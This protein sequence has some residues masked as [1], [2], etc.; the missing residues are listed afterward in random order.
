MIA[1]EV[2]LRR[3][4]M[5]WAGGQAWLGR[6]LGLTGPC[7]AP[8]RVPGWRSGRAFERDFGYDGSD[9]SSALWRP[10]HS[11]L[12]RT[13]HPVTLSL[14]F[15]S[16]AL[17]AE[18]VFRPALTFLATLRVQLEVDHDSFRYFRGLIRYNSF[19]LGPT[20]ANPM[21]SAG[22]GCPL[23]AVCHNLPWHARR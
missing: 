12:S 10:T 9:R 13:L 11:R 17:A 21:S 8:Q 23:V 22:S 15:T 3:V 5:I 19:H 14:F 2:R 16:L 6:E 20:T 4:K 18:F 7:R 1:A